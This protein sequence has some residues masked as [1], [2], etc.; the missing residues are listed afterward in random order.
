MIPWATFKKPG[1]ALSDAG[2]ER[3]ALGLGVIFVWGVPEYFYF[4]SGRVGFQP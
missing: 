2:L 3:S 4:N 1:P